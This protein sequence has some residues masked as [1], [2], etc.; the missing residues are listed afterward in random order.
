[1]TTLTRRQWLS[2]AA[3]P[4]A[5]AQA[6]RQR[7]NVLLVITD[8]QGYGDLACHGNPVIETPSLD[9]LHARSIRFTNFHVSPT[10]APT[11]SALLTG[12]YSNSTGAWHTIM[13]RSLLAHDEVTVASQFAAAGYRTGIFGKWH[14]GDNY[15]CRPIDRGFQEAVV[16]GGGGVW[17]APD[18]FGNDYVDDT[19][20]H[21]GRPQ[22]YQG[23][24]TDVFFGEATRFIND[25]HARRQPFF[26]YVATNS[27]HMPMWAQESD[28]APYRG[29]L[30]EPGFYGMI[31]NFDANLG[32]LLAHLKERGLERDTLVIFLTDNGT[33]SG[34][35]VF[36]AGMR[37]QKGSP[38][39]G[40]HRVPL[41]VHWPG[42]GLT[43]P[44]DIAELAAHIDL[45]PTLTE[46]CGLPARP[47][48]ALAL[49]GRSLV[50]LLRQQE[51]ASVPWP[52]RA[53]VVDSQRVEHLVKW[54]HAAV[55]TQR[56]RL[57]NPTADGK[58]SA[59]EL[60]D[61]AADPGQRRNVASGHAD[62]VARLT[63]SYDG[64]WQLASARGAEPVRIVIGHPREN[65]S[66]LTCH[67]WHGTEAAWNQ[68]A[69]RR[70]VAANGE[71]AVEVNRAG[72]Y[73]IELRRWP[74]EVGLAINA[75]FKD[76]EP[77]RE[78][79]PGQAI[80]AARARLAIAGVDQTMAVKAVDTAAVFTVQ[81][82]AGPATLR[83]WFYGR[84]EEGGEEKKGSPERGAYFVYAEY[85]A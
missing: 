10:C 72:R 9:A 77:N 61:M 25:A 67:D 5:P 85:V 62:V 16:C 30:G 81:L 35:Q 59:L 63:Q 23:F 69:I 11:R 55:M 75:P 51:P 41:F 36:N 42:G 38:Y 37:G 80:D 12:R 64:W 8:D 17:Q 43:G 1:M 57:V 83:T 6:P 60:Y 13:G 78:D 4:A 21:N 56:W 26:C 28:E 45:F 2:L 40:G 84:K 49:H 52:E 79:A 31:A 70:G 18:H 73:R 82:P 27:P 15:P 19:Y 71:W 74:R 7:P 46:L 3:A 58:L 14:L 76:A 34:A 50:P 22:R 53:L 66:R 65:P 33:A 24:C 47:K 68:R 39:D 54:K 32:R 29:K 48:S 20:F 44:R